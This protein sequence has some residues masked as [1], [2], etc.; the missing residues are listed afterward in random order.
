MDPL[1]STP[2]S[3]GRGGAGVGA[4]AGADALAVVTPASSEATATGRGGGSFDAGRDE[5]GG[6]ENRAGSGGGDET[7]AGS[8]GGDDIVGGEL[9][10]A[11]AGAES[12]ATAGFGAGGC[13][14]FLFA[15]P[16]VLRSAAARASATTRR[17]LPLFSASSAARRSQR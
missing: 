13:T 9:F 11:G 17:S 16:L 1:S 14:E 7:R 5:E 2:R 10:A 6:D 3:R 15:G 12:T 8:G 4:R